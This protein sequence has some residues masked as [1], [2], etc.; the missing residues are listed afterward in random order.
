MNGDSTHDELT[1]RMAD[2]SMRTG[3]HRLRRFKLFLVI[4]TYYEI[5]VIGVIFLGVRGW[6]VYMVAIH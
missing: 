1:A 6:N 3:I 4:L 5:G 2:G